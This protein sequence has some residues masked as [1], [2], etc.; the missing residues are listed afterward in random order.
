[1]PELFYHGK[2][3]HASTLN[4]PSKFKCILGVGG[5]K[6]LKLLCEKAKK[7]RAFLERGKQRASRNVIQMPCK[8]SGL[9]Q[10]LLC[11]KALIVWFISLFLWVSERV[12]KPENLKPVSE[13]SFHLPNT[14]NKKKNPTSAKWYRLHVFQN[15]PPIWL[16]LSLSFS[17]LFLL[18][19]L[20][21]HPQIQHNNWSIL[22]K[23]LCVCSW[24]DTVIVGSVH[25]NLTAISSLFC[26]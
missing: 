23:S 26:V 10:V 19:L 5:D 15:C 12:L 13:I 3:L 2:M 14:W 24:E 20:S 11:L 4:K 16:V 8:L 18:L 6:N 21:F 7:E 1:M 9:P 17:L 22:G 25:V